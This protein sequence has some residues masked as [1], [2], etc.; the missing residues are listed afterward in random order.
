[1]ILYPWS[2]YSHTYSVHIRN[3]KNSHIFGLVLIWKTTKNFLSL[4][5]WIFFVV[6]EWPFLK[7]SMKFNGEGFLA[8]TIFNGSSRDQTPNRWIQ[9]TPGRQNENTSISHGFHQHYYQCHPSQTL[10]VEG[11]LSLN[12]RK[13]WKLLLFFFIFLFFCGWLSR[14][15]QF[16]LQA[17]G[18]ARK[19]ALLQKP[20]RHT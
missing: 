4:G 13:C 19:C 5:L 3:L 7:F 12:L 2:I 11:Q 1:M 9:E 15:R 8:S 6:L 20:C 10:R 14:H 17:A 16:C 18:I